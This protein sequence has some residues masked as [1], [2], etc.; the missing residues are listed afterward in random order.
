MKIITTLTRIAFGLT[1]ILIPFRLR[2][3]LLTRPN[4]PIYGDFTDFL[5]FASDVAMLAT[6][7]LWGIYLSIGRS[8]IQL[9][10]KYFWLPLLGLT[11]AGWISAISSV[12][13]PITVYHSI[14]LVILFL[15]YLYVVNEIDSPRWLIIPVAIQGM[16]QAAIAI[17]QS[18]FQHSIGLQAFGE[19]FLDPLWPG[20]GI[21]SVGSLRLLR[22]Y[23]LSDHPNILGGCLAFGLVL[24]LA[25][26]LKA[27]SSR[28]L[29]VP[30]F[31]TISLGLLLTFSRSAWLAFLAGSVLIVGVEALKREWRSVR[32]VVL[33]SSITILATSPFVWYNLPFFGV[34]LNAGNSFENVPVENSSINERI[35]LVRSAS[36][37][38]IRHPWTG[39]GLGAS[40]LALKKEYAEFPLNYQPPH[41]AV[42]DS[43]LETGIPGAIFYFL[44][45]VIPWIYLFSEKLTLVR[46]ETI[47]ILGLL[48]AI[49]MVGLFDYYTWLSVSGRSWQW[50][51]WGLWAGLQRKT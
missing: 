3:T 50:L 30:A 18:T 36:P 5:L 6:L 21:V 35:F 33:L 51:A 34:R 13:P 8:R 44:L 4:I 22:A 15:F 11:L 31:L 10:P 37:I 16:I 46:P 47:A 24:L 29:I 2:I 42:F 39:I 23:G 43:M 25:A 45:I 40:P 49:T 28:W 7:L 1:I 48:A 14:R 17:A 20:V 12:D 27:K 38:F 9:G 32:D 19:Y 26:Y 41:L